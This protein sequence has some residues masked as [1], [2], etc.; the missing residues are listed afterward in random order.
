MDRFCGVLDGIGTGK[1]GVAVEGLAGLAVDEKAD[2]FDVAE[3]GLQSGDERAEGE[4]LCLDAGGVCVG[5]GLGEVDDGELRAG[6]VVQAVGGGPLGVEMGWRPGWRSLPG[7]R[8]MTR[9]L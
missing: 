9:A 3:V 2:L 6:G 1:V 7:R 8:R 4:V 5:E